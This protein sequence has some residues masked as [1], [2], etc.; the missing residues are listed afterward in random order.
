MDCPIIIQTIRDVSISK[1]VE[2]SPNIIKERKVYV[3]ATTFDGKTVFNQAIHLVPLYAPI[4][5]TFRFYEPA[6]SHFMI[7]LPPVI[8]SNSGNLQVRISDPSCKVEISRKDNLI[9]ITGKT[10][11]VLSV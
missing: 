6:E 11:E 3:R 1:E 10:G 8:L 7:R 9:A 2:S 4:D 5:D